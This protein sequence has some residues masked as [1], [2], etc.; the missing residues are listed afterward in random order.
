[1][2]VKI[3][4]AS[5]KASPAGSR[6]LAMTHQHAVAHNIGILWRSYLSS[7]RISLVFPDG[8]ASKSWCTI[9]LERYNRYLID[10]YDKAAGGDEPGRGGMVA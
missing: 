7:S 9:I 3:L 5:V 10:Q 4:T 2:K 1:M 8:S 6:H